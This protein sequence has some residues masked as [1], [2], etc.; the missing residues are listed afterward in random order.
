MTVAS[1]W[2]CTLFD[3]DLTADL[4]VEGPEGGVNT[5]PYGF[6]QKCPT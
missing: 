3:V 5:W 6:N 4:Y 2:S 1:Q